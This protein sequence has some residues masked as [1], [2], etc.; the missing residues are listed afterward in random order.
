MKELS[1]NIL[2]I[3]ENSVRARANNVWILLDETE[4]EL[5][6][7]V[8][9]DGCGMSQEFLA[10]VT[11]PFSTTR[12]TRK[13]GLGIPFFKMEAEQ[14]G[15]WFKIESSQAEKDH[16]TTTTAFFCKNSI[17]YIPL[18]DLVGTICTLIMGAPAIDFIFEHKYPTG[19]TVLRTKEMREILGEEVP[20]SNPDVVGWIR[21]SLRESYSDNQYDANK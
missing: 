12:T 11:D 1:L 2:D 8:R 5:K 20:L 9:D 19:E 3:A 6:I 7:T 14:T 4:S 18:G 21:E 15:G 13:V 17:D 16:G 10:T